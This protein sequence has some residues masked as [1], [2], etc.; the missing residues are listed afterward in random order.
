M[1]TLIIGGVA[2][3]ASVAARLRR[4][5]EQAEIIILE[6]GEYISFAN[7]G[8]PY[9]IGDVI[10]KK[11]YLVLQ[12]PQSFDARFRVEVR[13]F[14]EAIAID[15][16]KKTVTV[17]N[18]RTGES[19]EE[20]YDTLVLSPGAE[21]IRPGFVPADSDRI[22]TLRNIPDTYK[23][24]DYISHNQ[25]K[26]ALV[27]GGGYIGLEMIENLRHAGMDV[28]LLER[29][30][31]V[32]RSTL[33]LDMA[34]LVHKELKKQGVHLYF[35]QEVTAVEQQGSI[36]CVNTAEGQ[37][38]CADMLILA[39]GVSPESSLAK[40]AGLAVSAKGCI[41]VD[42]HLR[43]SYADIYALGDAIE[44]THFVSGLKAHIPLAGPA[45]RQGRIV[46]DNIAGLNSTYQ[47]TQGTAILKC[48]E[49]TVAGTGLTEYAAKAAGFDYEKVYVF[50]MSHASYYPN[51]CEISMKVL[52]TKDTGRILGAQLFG[53]DGV[54]KRCDVLATAIRANMT[55]FDLVHL[56]LCYAPPFSSAKDPVNIAGLAA[57]NILTGKIDIFHYHD[58]ASLDP[59][60]ITLLD[61]RTVKEYTKSHIPGFINIPL[62]SLRNNLD[63]LDV[64]KPV[65]VTCLA[66]LRSYIGCRIL[67]Q[68]GFTCKSLCGGYEIYC[69]VNN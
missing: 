46:A 18:L 61:V 53:K 27:I 59:E 32:L 22:F 15:P 28:T 4:L 56:E 42:E 17:K 39:I 19:Y 68:N 47:G 21:P 16:D 35:N 44:V 25:C 1:K 45:N 13:V 34:C 62:D 69:N 23:I 10:T 8:L 38:Y 54:D 12:T 50:P 5:D 51:A 31:Q 7:C 58:L 43:T 60:K 26:S 67:M 63:K 29:C 3:G 40:Q 2:G 52:F 9:Y 30:D 65:Y 55:M 6:R 41:Q 57:E 37:T 64:S 24:K 36:I 14:S 20:S 49:Q 11:E 33:D 66:G 48:F